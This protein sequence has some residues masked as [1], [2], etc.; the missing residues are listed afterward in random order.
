M[1]TERWSPVEIKAYADVIK[2]AHKQKLNSEHIRKS[3]LN[4]L[5]EKLHGKEGE[6]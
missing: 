4:K 6:K 1:S 2:K 3:K 5:F